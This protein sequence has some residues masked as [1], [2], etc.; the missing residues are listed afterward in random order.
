MILL[1]LSSGLFLGWS[2]GANDAANVFGT[3][4]ATRMVRFR[5]AAIVCSVFV[6]IGAVIAG[7]GA[8]ATLGDLGAVN[9]LGGSFMV[10]FAAALAVMWMTRAGLPVSTSQA[11]IGGIVGWNLF[12]GTSTDVPSLVK[13]VSSWVACPILAAGFSA[14][15]YLGAR[16][17]V[18]R[19]DIHLL[20]L[21]AMTRIFLIIA[22][23]FGAFALGANN[24]AN[25]MGVFVPAFPSGAFTVIGSVRISAAQILFFI[26]GLAIAIGIFSYSQRVMMTVGRNLFRLNPVTALVVILAESLVLFL[27]ASQGLERWLIARGLPPIPLVPVS[28]SQAVIGGVIGIALVKKGR[29]VDLGVL[30][31]VAGGWAATPAIAALV[32]F[33]GLFFL[34][35]VFGV[36]V[37]RPVPYELTPE[38]VERIGDRGLWTPGMGELT[39]VRFG[40]ERAFRR[41]LSRTTDLDASAIDAVTAAAEID[42][43]VIDPA[44]LE[45]LDPSVLSRGQISAVRGL[46]GRSFRHKWEFEDALAERD[47][48]W[49]HL[50]DT[51]ANRLA[52]AALESDFRYASDRFRRWPAAP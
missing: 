12:T 43:L 33:L 5:T 47:S 31:R 20:E 41:A 51:R 13:I 35:N 10:A 18:N 24:I 39:G 29:G 22:G 46:A 9:A 52:N 6:V 17:L 50:P 37:R 42:S 3:A 4:V 32:A 1:F 28:S 38:A 19:V 45:G 16:S 44:R 21:D 15:L 48:G 23:A 30:G 7:A 27:F 25:V 34:Q 11:I 2:L 49:V 8:T 36:E 40:N 14:A 26:G